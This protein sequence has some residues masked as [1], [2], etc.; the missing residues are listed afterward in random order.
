M[1]SQQLATLYGTD[2]NTQ[3]NRPMEDNSNYHENKKG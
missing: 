1:C 3:E 2:D